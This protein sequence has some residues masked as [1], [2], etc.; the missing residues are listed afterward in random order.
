[1]A[2]INIDN[3]KIKFSD[4][5]FF[6][7]NIW[8]LLFGT[9]ASFQKFEQRKYSNFFGNLVSNENSIYIT[10]L[11]LSEFS[12]VLLRRDFKQWQENTNS[13]TK[14]FKIDFVGTEEYKKSVY[15]IKI[16]LDKIL[17]V[18]NLIKIGDSLQTMDMEIVLENFEK[19]DFND[20]YYGELCKL[21]DYKMVSHDKDL[22]VLSTKIDLITLHN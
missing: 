6:D 11:V 19:I 15:S 16:L 13:Y 10:S 12:N 17:N 22:D 1:M 3:Y 21:Y 14:S 20:C 2:K 18:P 8:L 7:T 5:F 4:K 9:V